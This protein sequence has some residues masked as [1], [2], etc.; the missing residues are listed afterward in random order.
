MLM[1]EYLVPSW[2]N[3]LE[4]IRRCGSVGEVCHKVKAWRFQKSMPS[5]GFS[6]CLLLTDQDVSSQL[7]YHELNTSET[8]NS[9]LSCTF[10]LGRDVLS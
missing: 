5:P 8:I 9:M 2:R 3:Y 1:L 7:F 6:L 4:R 10:C